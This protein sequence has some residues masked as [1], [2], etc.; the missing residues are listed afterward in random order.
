MEIF[1]LF[2]FQKNSDSRNNI[3]LP[4]SYLNKFTKKIGNPPLPNNLN[5]DNIPLANN[6]RNNV[7][8]ANNIKNNI[9]LANNIRNNIPLLNNINIDNLP[10]GPILNYLI[11]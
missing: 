5:I 6:I 4:I 3:N 1:L 7:P 8:S 9:P 10:L 2:G 11:S